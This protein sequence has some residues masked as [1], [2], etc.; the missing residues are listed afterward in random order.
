MLS[1]A[2]HDEV[3]RLADHADDLTAEALLGELVDRFGDRLALACSFQKE[4]T[5][6]LD[7]LFAIAPRARVFAIDTHYLGPSKTSI[8]VS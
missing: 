1:A 6:L 3:A 4:E 8:V 2:A 7:M 5:V